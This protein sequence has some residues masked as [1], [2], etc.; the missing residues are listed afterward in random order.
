M[1]KEY[2]VYR[3]PNGDIVLDWNEGLWKYGYPAYSK[4]DCIELER[5]MCEGGMN[6]PPFA[7]KMK[8]KYQKE[9]FNH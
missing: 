8:R 6:L 9:Q 5:G 7:A 4:S 1:I 2:V 3:Y